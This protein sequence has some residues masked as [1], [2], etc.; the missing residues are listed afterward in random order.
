MV[1]KYKAH[2]DEANLSRFDA[3]YIVPNQTLPLENQILYYFV[4]LTSFNPTILQPVVAWCGIG[5][6][7]HCGFSYNYSGWEMAAWNCCPKGLSNYGK[8]VA[9]QGGETVMTSTHSDPLTGQVRVAMST[10]TDESRLDL[11][12]DYRLFDRASI[13]GEYYSYT[14]CKQF[15]SVPFVFNDLKLWDT[16]DLLLKIPGSSWEITNLNPMNCS[17]SITFDYPK[18]VNIKARA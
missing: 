16:K 14:D 8:S 10:E 17:G 5:L 6:D 13:T 1:V 4:G 2:Y 11:Y 9:L 3:T 18:E 15:N 7:T 12:G